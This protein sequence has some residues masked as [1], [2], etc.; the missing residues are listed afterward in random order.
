MDRIPLRKRWW[1]PLRIS[2]CVGVLSLGFYVHFCAAR[3]HWPSIPESK[4]FVGA[5]AIAC[6]GL[7]TV[8]DQSAQRH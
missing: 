7:R 3:Q 1:W 6:W 4:F 2:N 5:V 8:E